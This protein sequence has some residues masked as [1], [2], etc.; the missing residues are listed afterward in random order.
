M[1]KTNAALVVLLFAILTSLVYAADI[2][3]QWKSQAGDNPS[4]TFTLKSD[5]NAVS[6]SMLSE[7]GK[8]F[9]ISDGKLDGNTI[10][11][12]VM[13]EWQ[14]NPIK[15]VAKGTLKGDAIDLNIGTEDGSWGTE[16]TLKR[17]AQNGK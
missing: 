9:P 10:S 15:L 17:A 5:G 4:F 7:D 6:G 3:G 16:T 12:S 2:S 13:S 8:D 1:R 14:G 11:F